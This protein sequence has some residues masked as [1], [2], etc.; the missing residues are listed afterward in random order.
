MD[1]DGGDGIDV[2]KYRISVEG[3]KRISFA[4]YIMIS[5]SLSTMRV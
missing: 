4:Y 1:C 5:L 3:V 2:E